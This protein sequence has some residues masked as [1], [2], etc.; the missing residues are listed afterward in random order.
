M[1]QAHAALFLYATSPVH[2]G[3][4][5]AFGLIDNPIARERH[6]EHPVFPGS[7]LKGAIRHRF[8]ALPGWSDGAA[9]ERLLDRLFGPESQSGTL[10]AG[11]VSLGDAQLVAFPVRSV[12]EGYVY[13][14]SAYALAR[15]ARLLAQ[16]GVT[17][18]PTPPESVASGT[19]CVANSKLL[20]GDKLHLEAFEYTNAPAAASALAAVARWLADK[21]LPAEEAHAFFRD[22]F[23]RD[24]VLLSDEDFTWFAKN[25][26]VVEPHVRIDNKTGTASDGGLFY[27]ENLPPESLLLGSLMTS[28]ERSGKGELAA[29]AVLAQV[30]G[31]IDGKLLQVGGDATTGRGL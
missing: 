21:A 17:G 31:A 5:Q 14:T 18:M 20:A 6:S 10:H 11:A 29:E 24:L 27:T 22:K 13:A 19:C 26:T 1:F 2:M 30:K 3:A 16:L 12:K 9:G 4:G 7:G 23:A 28:R 15:A 8:H 25:A